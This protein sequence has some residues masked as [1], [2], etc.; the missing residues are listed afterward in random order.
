LEEEV[1]MLMVGDSVVAD[2]RIGQVAARTNS[3]SRYLVEFLEKGLFGRTHKKK[4]YSAEEVEG[5]FC[6][7][8]TSRPMEWWDG[9]EWLVQECEDVDMFYSDRFGWRVS[10]DLGGGDTLNTEE[11][12]PGNYRSGHRESR[13][14]AIQEMVEK[15]KRVKTS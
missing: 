9:F 13:E 7:V 12:E 5:V 11:T 1:M 4:W 15:V 3:R 6:E 14:D 2:G 10:V 8:E